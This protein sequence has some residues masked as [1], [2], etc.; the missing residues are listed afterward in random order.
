MCSL[1]NIYIYIYISEYPQW[2]PRRGVNEKK[3]SK[4]HPKMTKIPSVR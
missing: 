1:A 2:T 3:N 4:I